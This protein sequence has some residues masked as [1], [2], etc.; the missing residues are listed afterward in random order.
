M[1]LT[2]QTVRRWV[3]KAVEEVEMM[4]QVFKKLIVARIKAG[5][6]GPGKSFVNSRSP[7]TVHELKE[8][9]YDWTTFYASIQ[10]A[11]KV[12]ETGVLD[13]FKRVVDITCLN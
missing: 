5:M 11:Q 12:K 1:T 13:S 9:L 7:Q 2:I 8:V 10:F 4:R 3:E 6:N